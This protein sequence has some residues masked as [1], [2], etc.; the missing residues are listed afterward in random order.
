MASS[1]KSFNGAATLLIP[2]T[3]NPPPPTV[4]N[5]SNSNSNEPQHCSF[6][7]R[8]SEEV[9]LMISGMNGA[10]ICNYCVEQAN[11]LVEKET[12]RLSPQAD[13]QKLRKTKPADIK[14]H[15]DSY[16]IGQEEAK[17]VLAVAVYNHYKR[18][19][20]MQNSQDGSVEL[21]KSNI[22]L[23]GNTGTGKTLLARTISRILDVPFCIADATVLTEAGY[24][25]EDVE[26]VLVRLLQAADYDLQAAERGIVY[27]DEIEK[28]TR[29]S[30][31][32]SITR[33]VSG[34]GVQQALLKMLEGTEVNVPP[35]GGRK[36]PDQN[37]I[38]LDTSRILFIAGGAFNG[39]EKLIEDRLA[40]P[41]IGFGSH[42]RR[43]DTDAGENI[44]RYV[45]AEDLRKFGL[46]PEIIGR[47]PV[48]TH[49]NPLSHDALRQILVE[50]KNALV[51]QYQ[52]IFELD[53]VELSFDQDALDFIVEKA[54]ELDV[55]AR[56]LRS[57]MEA[58]MNDAMFDL[59]DMT[60]T[61][62]TVTAG[63]AAD[64]YH[65]N[66]PEMYR[67]AS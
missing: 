31:N 21:E 53:G 47:I 6:C 38:K 1:T 49:M 45:S 61:Q 34:E 35:Q 22:L 50:P 58:I 40:K 64:H 66:L 15:L 18:L 23:L 2:P 7:G 55:G 41:T 44:L 10:F 5:Q 56:G 4:A 52:R 67:Q 17:R 30:D 29:K 27:I 24:V 63:Y 51:K 12:A 62:F 3:D 19:L 11:E 48:L 54:S 46:I 33:D 20:D 43:I 42:A 13:L 16:V 39:L 26:N 36:H 28:I 59:P 37:Y 9:Y 25:G 57:I 65:R 14:A 60:E 32:S 8:S